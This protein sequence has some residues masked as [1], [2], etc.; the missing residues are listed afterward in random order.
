[1]AERSAVVYT[2]INELW[3][4]SPVSL[5]LSMLTVLMPPSSLRLPV[6][7][8]S[9]SAVV[10]RESLFETMLSSENGVVVPTTEIESLSVMVLGSGEVMKR[11]C[12][13]VVFC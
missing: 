2:I 8:P 12:E 13:E 9:S 5:K 7:F 11:L 4:T 10:E 6:K 3:A 1:M